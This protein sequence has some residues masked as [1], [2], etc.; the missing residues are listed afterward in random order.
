MFLPNPGNDFFL[1]KSYNSIP[2]LPKCSNTY[3]GFY[4]SSMVVFLTGGGNC[5]PPASYGHVSGLM[6][7]GN[8]LDLFLLL[9]MVIELVH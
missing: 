9:S 1:R 7:I 3:F 4:Y 5:P 8:L 2:K 6:K